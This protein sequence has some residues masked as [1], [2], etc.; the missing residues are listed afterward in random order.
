MNSVDMQH[1]V[2]LPS[3][4]CFAILY[5]V[6][7]PVFA[8]SVNKWG[9]WI[10][11]GSDCKYERTGDDVTFEV[12]PDNNFAPE[13]ENVAAPRILRPAKDVSGGFIVEVTV[14]GEFVTNGGGFQGAGLFLLTENDSI[15]LEHASLNGRDYINFEE[16]TG[17]FRPRNLGSD[18]QVRFDPS[19]PIQLRLISDGSDLTAGLKQG[20]KPWSYKT[21]H[22]DLSGIV[23]IGVLGVNRSSK[24]FK[25]TFSN[26]K[27]TSDEKL[28]ERLPEDIFDH[29]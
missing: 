20:D 9:E 6:G 7:N 5:W 21:D 29:Y 3:F 28:I 8:Q 18:W 13:Q 14:S 1:F 2:K 23:R 26:F 15:R 10:D 19:Q 11:P 4:F 16:R 24:D 27:F 17:S 25:P 12:K 22:F